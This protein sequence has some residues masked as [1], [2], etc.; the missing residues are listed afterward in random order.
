MAA[1]SSSVA[2]K[3]RKLTQ[4]EHVLH[5]PAMYIG[6]TTTDTCETW[7]WDDP[8]A[9]GSSS[10]TMSVTSGTSDAQIGQI[11]RIIKRPI[12]F[13]PGLFKCFDEVVVN[14][15]DHSVRM[16]GVISKASTAATSGATTPA[17]MSLQ[18]QPVATAMKIDTSDFVTVKPVKNIKVKIERETGFIEVWNDG[19]GIDVV[20]H[21]EH[22]VY[23]PELI[24]GHLLSGTNYNDAEERVT[25]GM[26]GLGAK[27]TNIFS[28]E[29]T[30]TTVDHRRGKM[31]T[32][33]YH[34]N[35]TCVDAPKVTSCKKLPFT[36]VRFK[37]DYERFGLPGIT[38]D[39]YGLFVKRVHDVCAVTDPCVTVWFNGEKIM[40]KSFERY[41]DLYI[42]AKAEKERF[43]EKTENGRWEV[44]VTTS[45][46]FE[47]VS[48]V[49]GVSTYKAGKHVDHVM[50]NIVKNL[51]D[52]IL[53][54]KKQVVKPQHIKD[55]I[56]IFIKATID[57]PTFDS[58]SKECL[59]TPA[60]KFGSRCDLSDKFYDKLFKSDII[61][62]VLNRT[63]EQATKD[64]KKTDGKKSN[65]IRNMAKLED[66]LWAGTAKSS[67]CALILT[68]GESA[69]GL[70]ISGLSVVGR[71][72]Y[73]VYP[74]RGKLLNV[75]DAAA[76]KILDNL[77]VQ[78]LK[79][80]LGLESGK[81]YTDINTLRYGKI[82]IMSD[83][84]L[85]GSH[86]KGLVMN[87]FQSL[88][89]SLIKLPGFLTS[90]LTPIIKATKAGQELA[91]F[92]LHDFDV[93]REANNNGAG[94]RMKFYK[95]LGTSTDAEAKEYFQNMHLIKYNLI[96]ESCGQTLDLAFNNK[97]ADDRKRW[98]G[99]YV[100]SAI[101]ELD[102]T[103]AQDVSYTDFINHDL[104][105]F[106][107]YDVKR[108]IPSVVDGLKPSQRKIM[109][110]CFKR[111]LIST[112]IKVAQLAGYVSENAAY[113]HG[114]ASLQGAII[115]L[116]QDYVGSNNMNLL[117]PN[118]NF[119]SRR[120]GGKDAA[121]PRYIYTQLTPITS[122]V[123]R[124][125]DAG[126]LKYLDDDGF[127]VEP[128]FYTP[129]LPMV[130]INGAVG[131][132]TG[133]STNI[134]CYHPSHVIA[135]LRTLVEAGGNSSTDVD[136]GA[137]ASTVIDIVPWYRGFKGTIMPNGDKG[138]VT[139]GLFSVMP[140]AA[141]KPTSIEITEL[142]IGTWSDDC[143]QFLEDYMEKNPKILRDYE[144]HCSNNLVRSI[145]HMYPDELE[146]LLSAKEVEK[147]FK[148]T[149]RLSTSNMHLFDRRGVIRKYLNVQ[150]II[151]D[152]YEVRLSFYVTRKASQIERTNADIAKLSARAKF[153]ED[154]C[155]GVVKVMSTPRAEIEA[156]LHELNYEDIPGSAR[157]NHLLSMPIHNLTEEKK[158]E[159]LKEIGDIRDELQRFSDTPITT[160]WLQE[161]AEV[162]DEFVR[163]LDAFNIRMASDGKPPPA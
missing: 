24:F 144:T 100:P 30:V 145:L 104:I 92:N 58:Q 153:I 23:V 157:Y 45:D 136:M 115:C 27:L 102:G 51:C 40:C 69:K 61:T 64:A 53:K 66:A 71:E 128:E 75:K 108:S 2:E 9:V 13:V 8:K 6:C 124:K 87:L 57:S 146:R 31:F 86:I 11:A 50:T 154:V 123:F 5:R 19:D 14:A 79:K 29:F 3:Y 1:S 156:R 42:G 49:N 39:M 15:I 41:A 106:S 78:E 141:P 152:F 129:V 117:L 95:G 103:E 16:A 48:F 161:L 65:K 120:L 33:T 135:A 43:Y 35:M 73:G 55:A 109:F 76:N 131:I 160:I 60:V 83:A 85:D 63:T 34:D 21:P 142:P 158:K 107:I 59:V 4:L 32:Q 93:W 133:F 10:D 44:V 151:A 162:E 138:Y 67:E 134:P 98:L 149:G 111:N 7:V 96:G 18:L 148:L 143:K 118:G 82:M 38:D 97:R 62:K 113:H 36:C 163:G 68:E 90:L 25:G 28:K 155:G 17:I 110:S 125:E 77:E 94:W 101:I 37:P 81:T 54:K 84:D 122:K 47:Q 126:L 89:P 70:A 119:G 147:E 116:A 12:T 99:A 132:G 26:N 105:H 121:S 137:A 80:I 56:F 46:S 20:M 127:P 112:E 150:E 114:E 88:W 22:E 72:K 159:L 52:M 140:T 139:R 130:L 74:L 91:F